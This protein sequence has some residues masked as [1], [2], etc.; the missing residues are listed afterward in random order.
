MTSENGVTLVCGDAV[1][2]IILGEVAVF[3]GSAVT[4]SKIFAS[5]SSAW[6]WDFHKVSIVVSGDVFLIYSSKDWEA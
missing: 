6:S 4:G 5:L 3:T 2:G 1:G